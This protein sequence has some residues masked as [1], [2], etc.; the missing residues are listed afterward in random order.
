M[1][2][3]ILESQAKIKGRKQKIVFLVL[4]GKIC[5]P[6]HYDTNNYTKKP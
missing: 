1:S 2:V 3:T 6:C 4:T 5:I